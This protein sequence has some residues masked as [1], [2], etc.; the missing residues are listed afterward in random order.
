MKIFSPSSPRASTARI[1]LRPMLW[2]AELKRNEIVNKP[3][4]N[5]NLLLLW[6]L[7][8]SMIAGFRAVGVGW[9]RLIPSIW[10][11][12]FVG[13]SSENFSLSQWL[14]AFERL[15]QRGAKAL[16]GILEF[17]I[18][19]LY[20]LCTALYLI[21]IVYLTSCSRASLPPLRNT[22]KISLRLSSKAFLSL[23]FPGTGPLKITCEKISA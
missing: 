14:K 22:S 15:R 8:A 12:I 17:P 13:Q 10:I 18:R 21:L 23:S 1:L 5:N 16:G 11:M 9:L 19:L 6:K 7:L 4:A 20:G 2:G 3:F